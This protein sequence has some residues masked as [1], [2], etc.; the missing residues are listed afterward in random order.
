M[1]TIHKIDSWIWIKICRAQRSTASQWLIHVRHDSYM[2]DMTQSPKIYRKPVEHTPWS[3]TV[4]ITKAHRS[5]SHKL[6]KKDSTG[7]CDGSGKIYFPSNVVFYN[8]GTMTVS[9]RKITKAIV[10]KEL[11]TWAQATPFQLSQTRKRVLH[12]C[13][14]RHN[15]HQTP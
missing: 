15:T 13:K 11:S 9:W 10:L 3:G 1:W 5:S 14:G 12:T 7:I 8:I 2:W 6:I 4:P